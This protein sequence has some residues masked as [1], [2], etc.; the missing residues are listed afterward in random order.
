MNKF[1]KKYG[2]NKKLSRKA[3]KDF[4]KHDWSGN[5]RELENTIENLIVIAENNT[6]SEEDVRTALLKNDK[7]ECIVENLE[8]TGTIDEMVKAYEAEILSKVYEEYGN[9][10]MMQFCAKQQ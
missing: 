6:I 5:V 8:I 4:L 1:N 3:Y 9:T 2:I 10:E 7:K